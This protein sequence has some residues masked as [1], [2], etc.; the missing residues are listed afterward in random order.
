MCYT[1]VKKSFIGGSELPSAFDYCSHGT[2]SSPL[3]LLVEAS[4]TGDQ[5]WGLPEGERAKKEEMT[6]MTREKG[7]VT[8]A[9]IYIPAQKKEEGGRSVVHTH[10]FLG[11]GSPGLL[12]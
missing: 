12:G 4:A 8:R 6:M 9:P 7:D 11:G 5:K 1:N 10:F 2:A 3:P